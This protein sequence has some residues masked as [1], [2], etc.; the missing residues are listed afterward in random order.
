MMNYSPF[1][2]LSSVHSGFFVFGLRWSTNH[3][4][5]GNPIITMIYWSI[6]SLLDH[7]DIPQMLI[8]SFVFADII[9]ILSELNPALDDDHCILMDVELNG[10]DHLDTDCGIAVSF[11]KFS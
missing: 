3:A 5:R 8:E 10:L 11:E 7:L 4:M 1:V 9:F 6:H 2:L